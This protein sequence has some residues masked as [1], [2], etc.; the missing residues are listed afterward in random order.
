MKKYK[1]KS[2]EAPQSPQ[3][4][5]GLED[6]DDEESKRPKKRPM[7]RTGNS[8][9]A[10]RAGMETPRNTAQ[11][12]VSRNQSANQGQT[13]NSNIHVNPENLNFV[14]PATQRNQNRQQS[15][16]IRC[17]HCLK[18]NHAKKDCPNKSRPE[19]RT[20]KDIVNQ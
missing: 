1:S 17:F 20:Q 6:S 12:P 3:G 13:S 15:S 5:S 14:S 11:T 16:Q 10:S 19:H 8:L 9:P 18:Y 2:L 4:S 7:I